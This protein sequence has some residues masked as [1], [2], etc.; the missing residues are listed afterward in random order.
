MLSSQAVWC[1]VDGSFN[2]C[3]FFDNIVALF[4]TSVDADPT[5]QLWAKQT[6]DWWDQ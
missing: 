5:A 1:L 4:E 3:R 2:N 6:L